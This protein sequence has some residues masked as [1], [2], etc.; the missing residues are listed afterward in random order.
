MTSTSSC[1]RRRR[2]RKRYT[3]TSSS[4]SQEKH[5]HRKRARHVYAFSS[6]S[7]SPPRKHRRRQHF[8]VE[9]PA[10]PAQ[11][12]EKP[13]A[14]PISTFSTLKA[15][16]PS[17]QPVP[18]GMVSHVRQQK[19]MRSS[20]SDEDA[21]FS[22]V[23]DSDEGL[24]QQPITVDLPEGEVVGSDTGDPHASS[25]S[26]DFSSYSQMLARLALLSCRWMHQPHRKRT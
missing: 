4:T 7:S 5:R 10:K 13:T 15:V 6:S 18:G 22:E 9:G 11:I 20:S 19:H 25:P 26:E 16:L 23:S 8:E 2:H 24:P 17:Q 3:S 21:P 14:A 12:V 1:K